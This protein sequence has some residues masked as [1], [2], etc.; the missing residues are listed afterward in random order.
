MEKAN[1]QF[2]FWNFFPFNRA[3]EKRMKKKE[4]RILSKSRY[5]KRCFYNNN[6]RK[7]KTSEIYCSIFSAA[8]ASI[9][10]Y[11]SQ[12]CTFYWFSILMEIISC[13]SCPS[14]LHCDLNIKP[15]Y[16][17][18]FFSE[19]LKEFEDFNFFY[20]KKITANYTFCKFTS[21]SNSLLSQ[22]P[23]LFITHS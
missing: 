11:A 21:D 17:A 18:V 9:L 6:M 3:H 13:S 19:L 7:K 1:N 2:F 20:F 15:L 16:K 8:A 22:L 10:F 4:M 23:S 14:S 12:N 5:A